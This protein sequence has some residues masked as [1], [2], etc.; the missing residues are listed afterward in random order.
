MQTD[1]FDELKN[2]WQTKTEVSE[3]GDSEIIKSVKERLKI[4]Q[5]KLIFSNLFVSVSFAFVFIVIGWIWNSFPDRTPYFY[6]S[7]GFMGFLL[8]S[9]LAVMWAGVNF[10]NID[11]LIE[12]DEYIVQ[13]IKKIKI[14]IFALKYALPVFLFLLLITF[15]FYYA[16]VLAQETLLIKIAAYAATT[17]YFVIVVILSNK[18]RKKT[19]QENYELIEYLKRWQNSEN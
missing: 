15:F 3:P 2:L 12:T 10:R 4:N 14:R 16:D 5:R 11:S 6:I 7:L 8:I 17:L 18:K 9:L 13:S 1:N 19:L